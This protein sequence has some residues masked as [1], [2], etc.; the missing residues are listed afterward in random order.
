MHKIAKYTQDKIIGF[1]A[2]FTFELCQKH[3]PI[4]FNYLVDNDVRLL[5][6]TIL[7][8]EVFLPDKLKNEAGKIII[9]VFTTRFY[10]IK[11]QLESYGLIHKK[12]SSNFVNWMNI[13]MFSLKLLEK[14]IIYSSII[15]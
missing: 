8:N 3:N 4:K 5:G 10:E 7:G 1:G 13:K 6:S 9:I 15:L 2:S 12:I 11:K 14:R